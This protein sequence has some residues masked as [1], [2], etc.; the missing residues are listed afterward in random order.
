MT[1]FCKLVIKPSFEFKKKRIKK[2]SLC[3]D[4][5]VLLNNNNSKKIFGLYQGQG[6]LYKKM[7]IN[8]FLVLNF[9]K[10]KAIYT[11]TKN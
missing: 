5:M 10:A 4:M 2:S 1:E 9:I 11:T 8:F 3:V 7:N 6:Y